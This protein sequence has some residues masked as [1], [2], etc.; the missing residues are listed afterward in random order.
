MIATCTPERTSSAEIL[1]PEEW[2]GGSLPSLIRDELLHEIFEAQAAST[3]G[4]IAVVDGARQ[5]T[6]RELDEQ[7]SRLAH[8]LRSRG[9]GRG[10]FVG[11]LIG[12]SIDAY[13][14]ILGC[15]K[16]GAAYVPLDPEYPADR[17][18]FILDDAGVAL[19]LT[20]AADA[21]KLSGFARPVLIFEQVARELADFPATQLSGYEKQSTPGDLCYVIYT[22]GSTGKPKG[23]EIEHRS[24]AHLV[25][26]ERWLFDVQPDDRVYQGFSL[27]FDASVEEVWLA[28]ASGAALVCAT[29]EMAH[30][31]PALAAQ[32]TDAGV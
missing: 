7:S 18:T 25:R 17:V 26:A 31:G 30:S 2:I 9:I 4:N 20:T 24:A 16:A 1:T 14:A 19:V 3:P 12:R 6:Y 11:I 22:S 27:A 8:L 21:A 10:S 28:F 13:T 23:V 5:I 15:L 32:L 29:R